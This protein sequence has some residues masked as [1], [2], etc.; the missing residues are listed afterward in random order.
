MSDAKSAEP[1]DGEILSL[2][3]SF[4]VIES[5]MEL[6][7]RISK[8]SGKTKAVLVRDGLRTELLKEGERLSELRG[9]KKSLFSTPSGGGQHPLNDK[10]D[11]I[12]VLLFELRKEVNKRNDD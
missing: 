1:E 11:E 7:T 5:D 6:L 4:D 2:K 10:L 3:V 9:L 12:Q 8:L